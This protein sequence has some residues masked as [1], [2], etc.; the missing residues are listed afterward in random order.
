MVWAGGPQPIG[1]V[2]KDIVP[3]NGGVCEIRK[4][5]G[6]RHHTCSR[7][8]NDAQNSDTVQTSLARHRTH[9]QAY[10][11]APSS[12]VWRGGVRR[13]KFFP[14]QMNC[15]L[16]LQDSP[17]D[18]LGVVPWPMR[19]TG[20]A[21]N[22]GGVHAQLVVRHVDCA[23][24]PAINTGRRERTLFFPPLTR[25]QLL[26][27]LTYPGSH[28]PLCESVSHQTVSSSNGKQETPGQR[29]ARTR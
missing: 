19:Y 21:I 1:A 13:S 18:P 20:N 14:H 27:I 22:T 5:T 12:S 28:G 23:A 2:S 29:T 16:P 10:W 11:R 6:A 15:H 24:T 9:P 26:S 8:Q 17:L 25:Q 7:R 3:Q 4:E